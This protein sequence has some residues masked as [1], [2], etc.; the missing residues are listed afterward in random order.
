MEF[1]SKSR[2]NL[3]VPKM[4][5]AMHRI[6]EENVNH[7]TISEKISTMMMKFYESY[8]RPNKFIVLT[9]I[10][11]TVFLLYRY[12]DKKNKEN[13]KNNIDDLK[14]DDFRG[15]YSEGVE[16]FSEENYKILKDIKNLQTS[17]LKYDTQPTFD[18]LQSV[19]KQQ[20]KVYYPPDPL[21]IN[22]PNEGI[23]YKR[24]I[25]DPPKPFPFM[26]SP[27]YNYNNVYDNKTNIYNYM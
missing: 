6:M 7:E 19:E 3:I 10:I 16:N 9:I 5:K 21:P 13:N 15:I 4:D 8:I 26:N 11:I 18:R 17:H 14:S 20:Q 23:T 12:Y 2:P 22:L 1:Y 24:E 25:Y 27:N